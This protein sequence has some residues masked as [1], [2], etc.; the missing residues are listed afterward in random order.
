MTFRKKD[1]EKVF[2]ELHP[3]IELGRY[4]P[5]WTVGNYLN[6]LKNQFNLDITIDD[7]KKDISLNLNE[8]ITSNEECAIISQSLVMRSYDIAANSSFVLK[9][10]NDE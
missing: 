9:Y 2:S 5:D 7:F 10:E 6:Y 8:E 4:L 3:T 1:T